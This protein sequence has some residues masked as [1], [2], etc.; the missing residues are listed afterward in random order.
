MH[1]RKVA[2]SI[3]LLTLGLAPQV[4]AGEPGGPAPTTTPAIPVTLATPAT[5]AAPAATNSCAASL[6]PDP[7]PAL[8]P[9]PRLSAPAPLVLDPVA[10]V[11]LATL[12][13]RCGC[14]DAA[15]VG[16]LTGASCGSLICAAN[17]LCAAVA[18][19]T[20]HCVCILPP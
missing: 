17:A 4:Q 5:L 14:G 15:C 16:K 9:A 10:S 3:L 1:T 8:S 11:S 18:P 13:R 19:A 7:S 6:L 2:L 20:S 12:P